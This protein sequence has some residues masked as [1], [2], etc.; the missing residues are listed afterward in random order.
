MGKLFEHAVNLLMLYIVDNREEKSS[1]HI[2]MVAKFLVKN[3]SKRLLKGG[4]ALHRSYHV[5]SILAKFSGLNP[6]GP[7]L[8]LEKETENFCVV[9]VVKS[10]QLPVKIAAYLF[11]ICQLLCLAFL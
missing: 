5:L 1:H 9:R 7:Y 2:V 3:K 4:F 11:S 8:S 10:S 6:K